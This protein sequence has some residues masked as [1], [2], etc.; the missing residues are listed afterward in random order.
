[1]YASVS[2]A[3]AYLTYNPTAVVGVHRII[4]FR[5]L[6]DLLD[7]H[8]GIIHDFLDNHGPYGVHCH[9]FVFVRHG[10]NFVEIDSA[11]A[12]TVG[13]A[14]FTGFSDLSR[15]G[16]QHNRHP[17]LVR[18]RVHRRGIAGICHVDGRQLGRAHR[19]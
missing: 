7:K 1:M 2:D 14:T 9:C 15:G 10:T 8:I 18:L 4:G 13:T 16:W 12:H 6:R 19:I 3:R 17:R 11:S 5:H